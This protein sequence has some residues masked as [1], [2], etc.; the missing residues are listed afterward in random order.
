VQA[1]RTLSF[2]L[3]GIMILSIAIAN[4]GVLHHIVPYLTDLGYSSTTAASLMSLHM[5]MLIFG[6]IVLGGFCRQGR[7]L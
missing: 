2:W 5:A 6:K 3:L 7:P 4:M 1:F